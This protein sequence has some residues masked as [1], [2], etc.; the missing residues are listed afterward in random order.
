VNS[1]QLVLVMDSLFS[2]C[3]QHEF[4]EL[5]HSEMQNTEVPEMPETKNVVKTKTV[6]IF[7]RNDFFTL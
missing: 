7:L 2:D 5:Q 1:Q 4:S 3:S 6:I